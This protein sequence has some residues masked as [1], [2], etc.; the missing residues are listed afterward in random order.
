MDRVG[1]WHLLSLLESEGEQEIYAA[2]DEKTGE[3]LRVRILAAEAPEED[4]IAFE[5]MEWTAEATLE[6][7]RHI[8]E[9]GRTPDGR[10]YA[11]YAP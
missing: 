4:K 6:G 5:D 9:I 8:R 1:N 3:G 7:S 11:V 10:P 2:T